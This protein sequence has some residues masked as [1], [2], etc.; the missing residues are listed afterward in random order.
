MKQQLIKNQKLKLKYYSL[1]CQRKK[2]QLKYRR[3]MRRFPTINQKPMNDSYK[4]LAQHKTVWLHANE[5]IP[6]ARPPV[7][8]DLTLQASQ[9]LFVFHWCSYRINNY[10][11]HLFTNIFILTF[12][13]LIYLFNSSFSNNFILTLSFPTY[14]FDFF[15][16]Q[17]VYVSLD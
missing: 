9:S 1:K 5:L 12:S 10:F 4:N 11:N 13:F 16:F 8:P 17:Y 15:L 6:V 3:K 14:L 7:H 2:K